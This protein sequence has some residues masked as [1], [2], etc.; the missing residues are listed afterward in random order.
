MS[1]LR[2]PYPRETFDAPKTL[3]EIFAQRHAG[4]GE[5]RDPMRFCWANSDEIRG[6][7][8]NEACE[9]LATLYDEQR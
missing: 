9:R 6:L 1:E 7:P 4:L 5:K 2:G 8:I 3:A